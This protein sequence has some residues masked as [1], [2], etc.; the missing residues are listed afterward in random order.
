MLS[1]F[2]TWLV[3]N[4]RYAFMSAF[5]R[6][7]FLL[8]TLPQRPDLCRADNVVNVCTAF[9]ISGTELCNFFSVLVCLVDISLTIALLGC[10]LSLEGQPDLGSVWGIPYYWGVRWG[11]VDL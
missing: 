9:P 1:D 8:T 3:A 6:S 11:C 2:V 7:G 4:S 10:V 5:L